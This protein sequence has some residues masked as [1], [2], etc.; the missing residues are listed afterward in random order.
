MGE[1]GIT[2]DYGNP[3]FNPSFKSSGSSMA[4]KTPHSEIDDRLGIT[5]TQLKSL[6]Q[7]EVDLVSKKAI[8]QSQNW[9]RRK[10]IL[11]TAE[12]LYVV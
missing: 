10:S 8:E 7:R 12:T 4:T 5:S 3:S 6:F 2:T 1:T 9:I 11:G